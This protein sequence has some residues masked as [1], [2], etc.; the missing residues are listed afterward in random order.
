MQAFRGSTAAITGAGSGIGRALAEQ[1]A[2]AGCRLFLSDVEEGGLAALRAELGPDVD[3]ATAIVDVA[4]RA[5]V[6]RWADEVSAAVDGL[7]LLVNNAGVTLVAPATATPRDDFEWLMNINFWGVVNGTEAFLPLLQRGAG[8]TL[9]NMASV[10]GMI[11]VPT[12]AAYNASKFAV[13]GFTEALRQDL[14]LAGS[15]VRVC[16]VQPGGIATNIARNARNSDAGVTT[17]ELDAAF[18][19]LAR[20]SAEKAARIILRGAARGRAR[21]LIGADARLIDWLVRLLPVSY[22]RV[23]RLLGDPQISLP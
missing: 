7:D 8:G 21:I 3:C 18:Q 16:C 9:V 23:M 17:E 13:R 1:L 20:T 4:D 12:Q 2:A 5:A 14:A 11:A 19:Q 10:F 6:Q 15:P 22:P